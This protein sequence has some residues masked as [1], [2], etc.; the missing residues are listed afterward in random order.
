MLRKTLL[1]LGVA[2]AAL[3]ASPVSAAVVTLGS[4]NWTLGGTQLSLSPTVPPGNQPRNVQ[5]II[6]GENQP[7]QTI[8]Y[9][10]YHNTGGQGDILMFSTAL[11]PGGGGSGLLNDQIGVAYGPGVLTGFYGINAQFSIGFDV[12]DTGTAQRLNS[13]Y[14][15]DLTDHAV[16]AYYQSPFDAGTPVPSLNN[17]TGFPDYTLGTFSLSGVAGHEILFFARIS[18]ANDG[19]DSFF[20]IA[21]AAPPVPEASTWAMMILGFVGIA[22][23]GWRRKKQAAAIA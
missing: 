14:V 5:C 3:I 11:A 10:D 16:L 15:L 23:Y 7:Q 9:N 12:N 21:D 20:L 18:G 17:G 2:A 8:G 6:C 19:P 1:A 13:F 4:Q 22:G